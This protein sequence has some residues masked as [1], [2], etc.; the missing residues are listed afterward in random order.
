MT[1]PA[2]QR[3]VAG[4]S[5]RDVVTASAWNSML[6]MLDAWRRSAGGFNVSPGESTN[7]D[8]V[9]EVKNDTGAD[10]DR[11]ACVGLGNV[12]VAP[13][14][15]EDEFI[16]RHVVTATT[17]SS[18]HATKFAILQ[19][20]IPEGEIGR[21]VVCG[22]T[23][24]TVDVIDSGDSYATP[25]VGSHRLR[26]AASGPVKIVYAESAGE[27]QAL[28]TIGTGGKSTTRDEN[29]CCGC[30]PTQCYPEYETTPPPIMVVDFGDMLCCDGHAGGVKQLR[31]NGSA[32][33]SAPFWCDPD[34]GGE[35]DCGTAVYQWDETANPCDVATAVY[36][37]TPGAPPFCLGGSWAVQTP[38]PE[39]CTSEEPATP[40]IVNGDNPCETFYREMPCTGSG[41]TPTSGWVL[42][43]DTCNCGEAPSPPDTDGDY[44][45]EERTVLCPGEGDTP[46]TDVP[47][48]GSDMQAVLWSGDTLSEAGDLLYIPGTA[49]WSWGRMDGGMGFG[50]EL[51]WNGCDPLEDAHPN[52]PEFDPLDNGI[53]L[54]PG[55]SKPSGFDQYVI[56][57]CSGEPCPPDGYVAARWVLV[58]PTGY[59]GAKLE[60]RV[61]GV[62]KVRYVMPTNR[63]FCQMCLNK[64]EIEQ[65]DCSWPCANIP[66]FVCVRPSGGKGATCL[67]LADSYTMT[68]PTMTVE[69]PAIGGI[70]EGQMSDA[71]GTYALDLVDA[72]G[73]DPRHEDNGCRTN[74][75]NCC[76]WRAPY[77]SLASSEEDCA[78]TGGL[79]WVLQTCDPQERN[80]LNA[81]NYQNYDCGLDA[82]LV[83]RFGVNSYESVD[84]EESGLV[85]PAVIRWTWFKGTGW[86]EAN[87][88]ECCTPGFCLPETACS[89]LLGN[90]FYPSL[91]SQTGFWLSW[92]YVETLDDGRLV[93]RMDDAQ[94]AGW[95]TAFP[96]EIELTPV[97]A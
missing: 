47:C 71:A 52:I 18:L 23:I 59:D 60:L 35:G 4:D 80:G 63:T 46:P 54:C 82:P 81:K 76:T 33:A 17:P 65:D 37:W 22:K 88:Y 61:G 90:P 75:V 6:D 95:V 14:E 44:D 16:E 31:W 89:E 67:P 7:G 70:D 93:M 66:E 24:A 20:A 58:P 15:N 87:G 92:N 48:D 79:G 64:M 94:Y 45:G 5:I 91:I 72:A 25:D 13:S 34:G 96:Q 10:L 51:A 78:L 2:G 21:A 43:S 69:N 85:G 84:V 27:V 39:G 42:V 86:S 12:T 83:L 55:S 56:T 1:K 57:A 53:G 32:W 19:E 73:W 29:P 50:Y 40:S 9:I 77:S 26:S 30:P 36:E 41:G 62:V 3:A 38:C 8:C 11:W 28:V 68:I 74:D 49:V 97:A